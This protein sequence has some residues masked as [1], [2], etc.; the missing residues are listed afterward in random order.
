V[1]VIPTVFAYAPG[2]RA[3]LSLRPI[4]GKYFLTAIQT[5]NGVYTMA[6]PRSAIEL[7]QM[8]QQGTSPSGSN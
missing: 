2:E 6:L 4:W 3:K 1:F 5:L 7:A 8:E